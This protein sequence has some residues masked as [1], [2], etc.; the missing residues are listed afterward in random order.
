[1]T[2]DLIDTQFSRSETQYP[3]VAGVGEDMAVLTLQG[4]ALCFLMIPLHYHAEQVR[5]S[6]RQDEPWRCQAFSGRGVGL[7]AE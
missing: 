4:N 5:L 6:P 1:M 3:R 2:S 7:D